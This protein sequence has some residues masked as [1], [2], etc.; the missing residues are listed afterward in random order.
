MVG[1]RLL[2]VQSRLKEQCVLAA[3]TGGSEHVSHVPT[4]AVV[5]P[6][7]V[8]PHVRR[9]VAAHLMPRLT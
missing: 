7:R 2:C 6:Q 1:S 4:S 5:T 9:A 3:M 8:S